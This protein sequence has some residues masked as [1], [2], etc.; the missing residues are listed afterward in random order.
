MIPGR[1]EGARRV[2]GLRRC[3]HLFGIFEQRQ[4]PLRAEPALRQSV[5]SL[6]RL[7]A[8]HLG[9]D[10]DQDRAAEPATSQKIDQRIPSR[11]QRIQFC[12]HHGINPPQE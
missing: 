2:Q 1:D 8:E 11:R 12:E 9:D 10:K 5:V 3:L 6:P 4:D 7:L